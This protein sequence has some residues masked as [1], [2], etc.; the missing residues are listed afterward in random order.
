MRTKLAKIRCFIF[1]WDGVFNNGVKQESKGS[2][3]S[4]PDSMGLNMMR[5]SHWLIH[6]SLPYIAIITGENNLFALEFAKRECINAVFLNSKNKKALVHQFLQL[7]SL[8]PEQSCFV[9]DDILDVDA[10]KECALSFCVKRRASVLFEN[11]IR[12]N[13]YANY[14]SAN[15]GGNHAVREIC[16]LI[17]GLNGNYDE[18][19]S[20]RMA[21]QGR[22]EAYLNERNATTLD[23]IS[24]WQ[25]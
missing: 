3:F 9:F 15:E 23:S 17:I 13:K 1:D 19:V 8:T 18:T 7:H 21:Y 12:T 4:E 24:D 20:K 6:G 16:E 5:F 14:I 10:S 2:S 22:Y 11:F 25:T